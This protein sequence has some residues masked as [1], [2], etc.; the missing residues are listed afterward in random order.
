MKKCLQEKVA[1]DAVDGSFVKSHVLFCG[2]ACQACDRD[3]WPEN[4]QAMCPVADDLWRKLKVGASPPDKKQM[5]PLWM[6]RVAR[7]ALN[8]QF[9][10]D[11][12]QNVDN[13]DDGR[14][15]FSM[16][17]KLDSKAEEMPDNSAKQ[18]EAENEKKSLNSPEG[19]ADLSAAKKLMGEFDALKA[20]NPEEA[21]AKLLE[22]VEMTEMARLG[23]KGP[24]KSDNES[25][26]RKIMRVAKKGLQSVK[27]A[28]TGGG[29]SSSPG[30]SDE[31]E[32]FLEVESDR[33]ERAI[34][35]LIGQ[36]TSVPHA[37]LRTVLHGLARDNA[38]FKSAIMAHG[39]FVEK[40]HAALALAGRGRTRK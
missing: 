39:V 14:D 12:G 6:L 2:F 31:E 35:F 27:D 18:K 23:G 37:E 36:E 16:A 13:S 22:A 21:N 10:T 7:H 20:S 32:A 29:T 11:T 3:Y 34:N 38:V 17:Q 8:L 4:E 30:K 28:V 25:W 9:W 40:Q 1:I 19:K 15:C 33:V 5:M 26:L 24:E